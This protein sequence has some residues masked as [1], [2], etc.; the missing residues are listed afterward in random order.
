MKTEGIS[1]LTA[2]VTAA[3]VT[4]ANHKASAMT[5]DRFMTKNVSDTRTVE[6]AGI[7]VKKEGTGSDKVSSDSSVREDSIGQMK[8]RRSCE[9]KPAEQPAQK[10]PDVIDVTEMSEKAMALLQNTFGL[11]EE[12]MTDVLEQMGIQIQDLLFQIQENGAVIVPVDTLQQLVME[13]HGVTDFAALLTND[14]LTKE[15]SALTD[16]LKDIVADGLEVAKEELPQLQ[17]SLFMDFAKHLTEVGK[18]SEGADVQELPEEGQNVPDTA[19]T[20][21]GLTVVVEETTENGENTAQDQTKAS[22]QLRQ[23]AGEGA[24]AEQAQTAGNLFAEK[25][26]QAYGEDGAEGISQQGVSMTQIVEQVV[27]QVKIR[28]LPETTSMELQ[29][30]PAS[31]G[32]VHL[33]AATTN[34]VSTATLTVENQFAKE[35]LE[36]QLI[37]LKQTFAE[38]GLKVDAVEVTVSEFSLKKENEQPQQQQEGRNGKR[39]F[40]PQAGSGAMQVAE[41]EETE[42]SRRDVQST[43]DYTA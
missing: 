17:E 13:V 28:I 25:L 24:G 2:N 10:E 22:S 42:A 31:L 27:R 43:V 12:E 38:Q 16:G 15:L 3:N 1:L 21:E 34:G 30:N 18:G 4:A 5:F 23:S 9:V 8:E 29:L 11:T 6:G 35:A 41:R 14:R 36:S 7:S 20:K 19:S 37:E 40:D 26:S 33:Q 32:R 39:T